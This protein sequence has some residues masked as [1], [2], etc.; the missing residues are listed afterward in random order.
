MDG[1]FMPRTPEEIMSDK[2]FN[3]VPL[4]VGV[5]NHEF[6]WNSR[7]VRTFL[8]L[9]KCLCKGCQ[10]SQIKIEYWL[11]WGSCVSTASWGVCV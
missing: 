10:E 11:K 7:V 2:E 4:M 3:A 9:V 1:V 6:G 5:T 8:P